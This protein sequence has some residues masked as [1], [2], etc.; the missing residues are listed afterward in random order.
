VIAHADGNKR[1]VHVGNQHLA[2]IE[3]GVRTAARLSIRASLDAVK[4][5]QIL[6]A[7][8]RAEPSWAQT[9]RAGWSRCIATAS[10]HSRKGIGECVRWQRRCSRVRDSMQ[11]ICISRLAAAKRTLNACL[12]G[13]AAANAV[14]KTAWPG[15]TKG[16]RLLACSI[17]APYCLPGREISCGLDDRGQETSLA[18]GVH[19]SCSLPQ[20]E[21]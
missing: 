2:G 15:A 19:C 21:F 14:R 9:F 5:R 16:P 13:A 18:Q 20:A 12:R 8:P 1:C 3:V 10:A 4:D 7:G 6:H 11:Q 17:G